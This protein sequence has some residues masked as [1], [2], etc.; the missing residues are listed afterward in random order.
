M[1]AYRGHIYMQ[2]QSTKEII[3]RDMHIVNVKEG[4]ALCAGFTVPE[5]EAK[6]Y[7]YSVFW[8]RVPNRHVM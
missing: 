6:Q 2:P 3:V 1:K 8:G 4:K 5:D 7:A